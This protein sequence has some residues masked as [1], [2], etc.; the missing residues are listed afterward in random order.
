MLLGEVREPEV[1]GY[2][3]DTARERRVVAYLIG[4]TAEDWGMRNLAGWLGTVFPGLPVRW[5]A[6]PDPYTNPTCPAGPCR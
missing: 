5:I 3:Q 6:T 1:L 2:L 4:H